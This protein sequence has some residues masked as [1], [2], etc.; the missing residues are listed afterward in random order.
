MLCYN[1]PK[2]IPIIN[3]LNNNRLV[4]NRQFIGGG[5]KIGAAC[6]L[7]VPAQRAI[8]YVVVARCGWVEE[9]TDA[10]LLITDEPQERAVMKLGKRP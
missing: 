7:T 5:A 4:N 10:A 3:G 8:I 1:Q 9:A 2:K 6:L